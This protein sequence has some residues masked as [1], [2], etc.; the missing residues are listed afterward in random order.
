VEQ[1]S[2]NLT[3]VKIRLL[4]IRLRHPAIF[5]TSMTQ[6]TFIYGGLDFS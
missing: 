5:E 1:K 4:R 3:L 2:D 6:E